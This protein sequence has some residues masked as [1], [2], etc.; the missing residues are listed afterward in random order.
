MNGLS[1]YT[2]EWEEAHEPPS[3]ADKLLTIDVFLRRESQVFVYL[4]VLFCILG[5]FIYLQL[6]SLSVC[7]AD[8]TPLV[9]RGCGIE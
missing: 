1:K 5:L 3:L 2:V 6:W 7:Q 8:N 4:F 9:E